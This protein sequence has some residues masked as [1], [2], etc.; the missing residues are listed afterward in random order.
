[1]SSSRITLIVISLLVVFGTVGLLVRNASDRYASSDRL[2]VVTTLFPLSDMARAIGGT[3]ADITLLL[4]PGVSPHNYEPTPADIMTIANADV[5]IYTGPF[6]EPW[7]AD[8]LAGIDTSHMIVVDASAHAELHDEEDAEAHNETHEH[9]DEHDTPLLTE[10]SGHEESDHDHGAHDPHIWLSPTNA[11]IIAHDIGTA[12]MQALPARESDLKTSR[13]AYITAL[14]T[15]FSAYDTGLATCATRTMV[16]GGHYAFGYI[17]DAFDLRY[18]TAQGYSP[19]AEPSA[20]DLATLTDIITNEGATAIFTNEMESPAIAETLA[21]ETGARVLLLNPAGNIGADA[22]DA[23]TTFI[24]ILD[25]NL[26]A[27]REGLRC[28]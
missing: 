5:F 15:V 1:M 2:S 10:E 6:M 8:L 26:T 23:G 28:Q 7:V 11:R 12:L 16:Y 14:D 3:Y 19:D 20:T 17:A 21:R 9:T 18:I 27:L 13:D 4:P 25:L 24:D 22:R